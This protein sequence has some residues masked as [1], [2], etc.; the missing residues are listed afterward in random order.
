MAKV[1]QA[2]LVLAALP[3]AAFAGPV[4]PEPNVLPLLGL[5]LVAAAVIKRRRK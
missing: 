1:A 2:F 3:G 5:G 4:I